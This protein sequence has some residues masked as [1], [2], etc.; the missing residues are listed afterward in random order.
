MR[1]RAIAMASERSNAVGTVELSCEP[2]A[3]SLL[4]L[5]VGGFSEGYV[6][7]NQ[8]QSEK[9]LVPW[10]QL[11]EASVDGEQVFLALDPKLCPLNRLCLVNFST[12]NTAHHHQLYRRRLLVRLATVGAALS[13]A[14]IASAAAFRLAPGTSAVSALG[15]AV[16]TAVALCV[17]GFFADQLLKSGGLEGAMAREAFVAELS[18]F[19]PNLVRSPLSPRPGP[20]KTPPIAVFQ[21]FLPRTTAAIVMSLTALTLAFVLM[22]RWLLTS[23]PAHEL[24]ARVPR[25]VEPTAAQA[26]ANARPA[27]EPAAAAEAH[28][29]PRPSAPVA[30]SSAKPPVAAAAA[31]CRCRRSD[32]LLWQNPIPVL[33][34]MTLSKHARRGR[35]EDERKDKN[36]LELD[37]GVVNNS[38]Q[39]LKNVALLVE[40]FERDP[41]PSSK[42]YSTATRP[43]FF[44]GPLNP[45]QAIKWDVEARGTD[46]EVHN[47][48][49]ADVGVE[50]ESAAPT[51]LLAELLHAHNRPVRM[52][53]AMLLTFFGDPRAKD[54]I[55]ELRE[56]LRE[57]EAPYLDRLLQA[58]GDVRV[59]AL[60]VAEYGDARSVHACVFNGSKEPKQ[61][62]GVRVRGLDGSDLSDN[63]S[64][65]PPNVIAEATIAVP[66]ELAPDTGVSVAGDFDL[67][68]TKPVAFEAFADRIDL[69][70]R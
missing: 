42:R 45:G 4:Y 12:G 18:G 31:A 36:Y 52:H 28:A 37:I 62:L 11:L 6:S 5:Q 30:S 2:G 35:E 26:A 17:L 8:A 54:A 53:G 10:P 61:T 56:A 49:S 40:F 68:G 70:P 51:N 63:P 29:G 7:A 39:P 59:C 3:L 23:D 67:G 69:L 48:L 44:E 9:L 58:A 34:V 16:V 19:V 25:F 64:G 50:G 38:N 57:D 20:S 66:G 14:L 1:F 21:G 15:I 47:A 65:A 46:Y 27:T 13:G 55:M 41:P 60:K 33:S 32:S 43:L 24:A 22:V